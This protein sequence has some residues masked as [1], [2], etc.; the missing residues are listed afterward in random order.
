MAENRASAASGFAG[1]A[2]SQLQLPLWRGVAA[3]LAIW[4]A[5]AASGPHGWLYCMAFRL[6]PWRAE[7][8]LAA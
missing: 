2:I 8:W 3:L 6:A 7:N 4:L 5:A 1:L